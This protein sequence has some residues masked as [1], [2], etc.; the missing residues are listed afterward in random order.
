MRNGLFLLIGLISM[1]FIS[2]CQQQESLLTETTPEEA[3]NVD[4]LLADSPVDP[5]Q[6]AL[7][8]LSQTKWPNTAPAP[9]EKAWVRPG[10][11]LKSEKTYIT[12]D[13]VHYAFEIAITDTEYNKVG[14]H[15]VVK[16]TAPGVPI[17]TYHTLFYQHGDAKNFTGMILPGQRSPNTPDDFGL[18]VY[19][20]ENGVDVWGIDQAWTLVP[21]EVTDHSFMA[22]WGLD[23]QVQDLRVAMAVARS[24]RYWTGNGVGRML[25]AGYSSG[26]ATGFATVNLEADRPMM[27]R[28][29]KGFIP[30]DLVIN[31]EDE[32]IKLTAEA[33][34]NRLTEMVDNGQYGEFIPFALVGNLAR[35]APSGD[36]PVIP[37]ATNAQAALLMGAGPFVSGSTFH[38]LAGV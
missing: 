20:A 27:H 25:L 13:I 16:E 5:N 21:A 17:K 38:Y 7:E 23:R 9:R 35:T 4:D 2:S 11:V 19:L 32:G 8:I 6:I 31:S 18:A 10:K 22:D 36:S 12:D 14:L 1:L 34:Y 29:V 26:V 3:F 15:R 37:G 28:Q 24:L 33:D 30:I